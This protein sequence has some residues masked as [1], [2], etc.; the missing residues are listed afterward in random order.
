M[1]DDGFNNVELKYLYLWPDEKQ[2]YIFP[3]CRRD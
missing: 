3:Q 1:N 2:A